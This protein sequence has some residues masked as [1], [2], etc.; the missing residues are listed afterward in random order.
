MARKLCTLFPAYFPSLS[1]WQKKAASD[2]V[3]KTDNMVY[4]FYQFTYDEVLV[5]ETEFLISR[6][7]YENLNYNFG[8]EHA[9]L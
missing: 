6:Q 9:K 8:E 2:C 3:K 4:K 1:W 7:E 5:V